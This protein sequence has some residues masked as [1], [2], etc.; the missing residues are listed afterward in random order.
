MLP[1]GLRVHVGRQVPHVPDPDSRDWAAVKTLYGPRMRSRSLVLGIAVVLAAC[2]GAAV[3]ATPDASPTTPPA[4]PSVPAMVSA[5][6]VPS[7]TPTE[8]PTAR[9]APPV[10]LS[11]DGDAPQFVASRGSGFLALGAEHVWV[12]ED[13]VAWDVSEASLPD[14]VIV[15]LVERGDGTFLAFGYA[16][17]GQATDSFRT[18]TSDDGRAWQ[19]TDGGLPQDFIFLDIGRGERGYVLV[20]RAI[21]DGT[22]PEQLW[23]SPD[24]ITWQLVYG[25]SD[26]ESL[27]AVGA[28]PEGFVAVGQQGFRTGPSR[29]FV[30]ATA[31][32][33]EWLRPAEGG[34][35]AD[36]G[37]LWSVVPLHGDWV[38]SPA[39]VGTELP[40]LWSPNGLDWEER[41]SFAIEREDVGVIASLMSNGSRLYAAVADGG[42][43][44]LSS[45]L[46]TSL[47]A[48]EWSETEIPL[49]EKWNFATAGGVDVFLVDG[50]VHVQSD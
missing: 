15:R 36:S 2:G 38:T 32:G 45:V 35:L 22:S 49:T 16:G 25:T 18:W 20:G 11:V 9:A 46:L 17:D 14:G 10:V 19:A 34:A 4:A 47:D 28:G 7:T 42:G 5:S 44:A 40:I 21:L 31:D 27:A 23:F 3:S 6:V 13:G 30:L 33:Q 12:S 50:T 39:T 48:S 24:A 8:A 29:A 43:Q 1:S 37:S 41:T 26:N